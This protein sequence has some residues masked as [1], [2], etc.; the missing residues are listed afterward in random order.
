MA[1]GNDYV[2]QPFDHISP[3]AEKLMW[4]DIQ[5]NIAALK[6]QGLLAIPDRAQSLSALQA[7]TYSFPLRMAPG[8]PDNAGFRVSAF[9]DDN[10][11]VGQVIDYNGGARTYDGHHGTDYALW[12]FSWN[13]VDAADVQVIAAAAG[14]IV[15]KNNTDSSDHNPCDSGSTSD[16]WNY[17]ALTHADGRMTIYGHMGYNSLTAKGVGQTVAQGEYLGTVASSGNSSGPHLHF[18]VRYGSY[19]NNEWIDPY[20]GPFSHPDS[21]W[22]SQRPYF[23]SGIN[24]LATHSA[25]PIEA[26][27]K[28]T[29]T[30][31]QDAFATP[32]RIYFYAYYRDY[33]G[34]LP[35]Q[36][37]I[38]RPDGSVFQSWSYTDGNTFSSAINRYWAF[39]FSSNDPAG[40]W[41]FEVAYNGQTYS[42]L[43]NVNSSRLVNISTRM[44]VLTGND[45]MIGG[46]IIGGSTSKTVVVRARGPSMLANGIT[47]YLANPMLQLFSGA[48]QIASNDNWQSA[49]NQATLSASGF[50]P[51]DYRESAIYTTLA[52]GA[53]TAIVTGVGNTTGVAIVEVFEVDKPEVPLINISTRGQVL[54]GNDVMIGG[55]IIQGS[56]PQTVVVRARG[57]SMLANG[58]ANYLANPRL[59]LFSGSTEI[60]SN[61][62][63]Q[64]A[65]NHAT[66][67]ASGFA[68]SD[69]KEA[70]IYTTLN[71]GAYTVIVTG[72]GGTTGVGIVEVFAQ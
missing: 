56:S 1:G 13:K 61:D 18:E 66:L 51:S 10:S 29:V 47:N 6:E 70:A 58:I 48:T 55:F 67:S 63:W 42:T 68:P 43:F 53:Y 34:V 21:L 71:P 9:V 57:P 15:S 5:R 33:Q 60:G 65:T 59:Q 4:E 39:D 25:Q 22:T 45:V 2:G 62:D 7:V 17:V 28:P 41:R 50:A 32:A 12:P 14:T 11:T 40:I 36:G 72:V 37:T 23:D 44:Q 16:T 35:T 24:R 31:L 27:C 26:N 69:P 52:P 64:S 19:S 3:T 46:L 20:S 8:R 38:F 49:A 30:N 54:T